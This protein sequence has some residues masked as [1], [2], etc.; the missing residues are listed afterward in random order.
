MILKRMD[1][2]VCSL[3]VSG[4]DSWVNHYSLLGIWAAGRTKL[5]MEIAQLKVD[6]ITSKEAALIMASI[7]RKTTARSNP[8]I[9]LSVETSSNFWQLD[10]LNNVWAK[11]KDDGYLTIQIRS[12]HSR[13]FAELLILQVV[14]AW[15]SIFS[16]PKQDSKS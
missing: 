15:P 3:C 5:F 4:L 1:V 11:D 2:S 6:K 8:D 13:E 14:R 9:L 7:G 12:E 16:T 10:E